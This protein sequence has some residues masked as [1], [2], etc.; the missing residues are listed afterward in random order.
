MLVSHRKRF[1]YTKTAKTGGTSVEV[2]F[3]PYCFPE[4]QWEFSHSRE[5]WVGPTGIVGYRGPNREGQTWYHH[6]AAKQ[7]RQQVGEQVWNS[8]FKFCVIRD[9]FDK[10]VSAFHF[11]TKERQADGTVAAP[12]AGDLKKRFRDWLTAGKIP[13]DG[14]KY[15]IDGRI[16]VDYFIR[17]ED[18]QGGIRHVC[19]TLDIPFQPEGLMRLKSGIRPTD[20]PLHEYYDADSIKIVSKLYQF[21][22]KHFGYAPPNLASARAA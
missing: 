7:I 6:M 10:M 19:K 4:G 17:Y 16:C 15:L 13:Y 9:P 5:A 3:E 18:M 21:E 11:F 2:Y 8:Y 14:E 1:I 20:V 22:L 12:A